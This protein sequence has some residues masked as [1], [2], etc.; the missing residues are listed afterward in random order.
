MKVIDKG[1]FKPIYDDNGRIVRLESTMFDTTDREI[2]L[3]KIQHLDSH[4]VGSSNYTT[5]YKECYALIFRVNSKKGDGMAY[6]AVEDYLRV[7]EIEIY[8][9]CRPKE[10]VRK[11][12]LE[13][14]DV[15]PIIYLSEALDAFMQRD[16]YRNSELIKIYED[17]N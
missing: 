4:M 16:F 11:E 7:L 1:I 3:E 10:M 8:T 5:D 9:W 6:N 17:N 13:G 15:Y 12:V 14:L 2:W